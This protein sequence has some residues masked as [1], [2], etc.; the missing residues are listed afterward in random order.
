MNL[1]QLSPMSR[2][3]T[4]NHGTEPPFSSPLNAN[5][6]RGIYSCIVCNTPVFSSDHK[7][8]SGTGWPSFSA[9]Y[10]PANIATKKDYGL[11]SARTEVHCAKVG[12]VDEEEVGGQLILRLLVQ[13]TLWPCLQRRSSPDWSPLLHEWGSVKLHLPMN[14]RCFYS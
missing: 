6:A 7:Y 2:N 1:S 13:C 14:L 3:V 8:D 10:N 5:K 9:P 11:L 4:Q 12:E